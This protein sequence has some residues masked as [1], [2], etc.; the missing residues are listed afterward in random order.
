MKFVNNAVN[1]EG[2]IKLFNGNS[3]DNI[4]AGATVVWAYKQTGLDK[5]KKAAEQI[6]RSFDGY[7]R[8]SDSLF[9]HGRTLKGEVWIDGSFM[10]QMFLTEYGKYVADSAYCFREAARQ[11]IGMHNHLKK[12]GTGLMYHAWD[13]DHDAPWADKKTGLSPEVWSEGLGWYALTLV[14]TLDIYPKNN[15]W[16]AELETIDRELMKSLK[17]YQDAKTGLWFDI[18]DKGNL[19]DNFDDPSGSAMFLYAIKKSIELGLISSYEYAG[20]VD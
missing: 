15:P 9:W 2:Y 7:P 4:M 13:E 6:R 8:T 5:Y 19:P 3:L 14:E 16:R 1:S 18:V 20:V 11:L 12:A 17:N 10:G